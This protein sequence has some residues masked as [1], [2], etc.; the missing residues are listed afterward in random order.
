MLLF[1]ARDAGRAVALRDFSMALT[2]RLCGGS[3]DSASESESSSSGS[4][5]DSA[6]EVDDSED[7]LVDRGGGGAGA[8]VMA[9]L[10]RSRDAGAAETLCNQHTARA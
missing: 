3:L 8:A 5:D 7:V 4:S 2:A 1:D 9:A 10:W 6:D